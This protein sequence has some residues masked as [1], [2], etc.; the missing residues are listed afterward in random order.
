VP[1]HPGTRDLL[2][3]LAS[4]PGRSGVPDRAVGIRSI[5]TRHEE[6]EEGALFVALRGNRVDGHDFLDEAVRRGAAALMVEED[7]GGRSVPVVRVPDTRRALAAVA[8]E[9][10]GRP[11]DRMTLVGITG[12]VGKTS[13]LS[14]L[15]AIL[16]AGGTRVGSIG[17]LGVREDGTP[18]GRHPYT[19]PDPLLLHAELARLEADGCR[20]VA[21]E[22]TSHALDQE[23]VAGLRYALGVFTNLLPLEHAEYH[24]T[25]R[26]YA[27][28]KARFFDHLAAGAPV[29]HNADD[30][31]VRRVVRERAAVAVG[32][33][34]G[35]T[36]PVRIEPGSVSSA[37]TSLALHVRRPYPRVGGGR[38]EPLRLPLR[39]RLLGRSNLSNAALAGAAALALG[40]EA[41]VVGAVLAE[42]RPARRRMEVLHR[43]RFV[44]LDDTVG[45][46]DSV[47][48]VFE[49]VERL[50]PA[51]VLV[52]FAVRGRRGARINRELGE[53]LSIWAERVP[54][55]RL[56]LTR[57]AE[58]VDERNRVDDVEAGAL[59]APLRRRGIALEERERLDQAVHDVLGGA[60]EGDVVLLLGAQGM[61]RG[62]EYARAWLH[63]RGVEPLLDGPE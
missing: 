54:L 39:M 32:C 58:A 14:I 46:P 23:R 48:A 26:E 2:H 28:V 59:A 37:G 63:A 6:V 33:G 38:V 53:A 31:A 12:T 45:H 11:A 15:E 20:L 51:R 9:W 42:L 60:L 57:S 4:V 44:V 1:A 7:G 43:D 62:M 35:R 27:R 3:L 49:V 52:A 30:R 40:V 25:F 16:A 36:A 22:V 8:A 18:V 61:D 5:A 17:S 29:I 34:T 24:G 19:A 50:S 47:S 41:P 56:V 10:H 13:T 55:A 21:M